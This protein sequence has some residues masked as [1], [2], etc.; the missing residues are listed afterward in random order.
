MADN[1]VT[2][3]VGA[4]DTSQATLDRLRE[5]LRELNQRVTSEIKVDDKAAKLAAD[6]MKVKLDA[7]GR[8]IESPKIDVR[9]V[10]RAILAIEALDLKMDG[11]KHK[12]S[13]T[14]GLTGVI[15]SAV[16]G[17]GQLAGTGTAVFNPLTAG[18]AALAAIMAGPLIAA[19]LP[20]T[21]GFGLFAAFAVPELTKVWTAV[22]KGGAA[23]KKLNP[24]EQGLVG[25]I[26]DLKADFAGLAKAIQPEVLV[27]FGIAVGIVKQ[28]MPAIK[29]LMIAAGQATEKFLGN[30]S[31]WIASPSGK[32][33]MT[34][35]ETQGPKDI[36]IF[37]Q[38]MW[39]TAQVIGRVFAWLNNAGITWWKNFDHTIAMA[40]QG[41]ND[42]VGF[43]THLWHSTTNIFDGMR[44]DIAHDWDMIW[45]NTVGR[46]QRGITDVELWVGSLPGA[47]LRRLGSAGNLLLGWGKGVITGLWHGM[48]SVIDSVGGW[49]KSLPGRFLSWLGIKSPPQWAIDA[50]KHIMTGLAHG[51]GNK[52][53]HVGGFAAGLAKYIGRE[54]AA[55]AKDLGGWVSHLF[56]GGGPGPGVLKWAPMV[57]FALGMLKL[58]QG[59]LQLVLD[60]MM[61]ESGG[62]QFAV[63][64]TDI[65]WQEGHP[66]VGLMQVI[67][68]TFA[69][70]AGPFRNL[71]PFEYGVSTNP[72][73][74]IYAALNYAMQNRGFGVGPGQVGSGH[75]YDSGG[76]LP[77]GVSVAVNRTGRPERVIGPGGIHVS[78]EIGGSGNSDFDKFMLKWVRNN[79]RIKGGGSVQAAFGES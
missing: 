5:K 50:G 30:I 59:L 11:L 27:S 7:I 19:L 54:L 21:A 38:V 68:G 36:A 67:A 58:P 52:L 74:N 46:V 63:N 51:L 73:A 75:G 62:N 45:N 40:H 69:R 71:G 77:P 57:E 60:Q 8:K 25:P 2:I 31:M 23:L 33:F 70:Y 20:I 43:F 79:V 42:L 39:V 55:G 37:G 65:N 76:W 78:L 14:S 17:L 35:L 4:T 3:R 44:H 49:V 53:S 61:S 47:L 56:S 1:D 9:G 29:P 10:D 18:A 24:M 34:W 64:K 28:L 6:T 12:M 66:S 32:K 22:S 41:I 13:G 16:Q 72:L 48:L 26:R 15:Y